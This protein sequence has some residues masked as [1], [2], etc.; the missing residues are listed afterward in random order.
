M[1][2]WIRVIFKKFT[3]QTP[4]NCH[5]DCIVPSVSAALTIINPGTITL[6]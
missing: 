5:K 2:Q 4:D 6:F 3:I 1:T